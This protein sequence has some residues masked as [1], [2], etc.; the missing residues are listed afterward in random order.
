[1]ITG[2]TREDERALLKAV[3][4]QIPVGLIAVDPAGVPLA[5]SDEAR[6]IFGEPDMAVQDENWQ[7]LSGGR[8]TGDAE[9]PLTRAVLGDIVSA[10]RFEVLRRDGQRVL[11]EVSATPVRNESGEIVAAVA[12]FHDLTQRD[13]YER[14]QRDFITNAAHEL[15]SP[16]AAIVSAS[17]V[18]KA[19]AK[20]TAD[21]DLFLG[22]IE[23]EADRL[24]HLVRAMLTLARAQTAAEELRTEVVELEPLLREVAAGLEP[25]EDVTVEVSCPPRLALLS[26]A[27]LVR[28]AVENL[29]RNATKFTSRGTVRLEASALDGAVEIVVTDTGPG[30]PPELRARVFERFYQGTAG[31]GFGLGL[32]IVHDIADALGGEVSVDDSHGGTVIRLRLPAAASLVTE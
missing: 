28:H 14:A 25:G 3:V 16:L 13:D 30:I 5:V 8:G 18:L 29:G 11:V 20:E 32:S 6:K 21:R 22:H 15:Q 7:L 12:T 26:N 31:E 24:T 27:D 4:C 19:G 9:R 10:E 23:R 2:M 1:M 17:D